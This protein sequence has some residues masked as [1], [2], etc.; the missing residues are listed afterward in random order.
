MKLSPLLLTVKHD[1]QLGQSLQ[2]WVAP[3]FKPLA[4]A[5]ILLRPDGYPC[6][7]FGDLYG[8]G[9]DNPQPPVAQLDDLIR[10]RK[11]YA[12]GEQVDYWDHGE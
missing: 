2:N 5:L 12:Y 7:F 9:G 6:V 3:W 10:A 11:L 8:C 4:Y 1:T